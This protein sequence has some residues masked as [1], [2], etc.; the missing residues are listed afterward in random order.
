MNVVLPDMQK[1]HSEGK[2]LNVSFM[3]INYYHAYKL[4]DEN[5]DGLLILSNRGS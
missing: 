2:C 3:D 1:V 4:Y 5:S